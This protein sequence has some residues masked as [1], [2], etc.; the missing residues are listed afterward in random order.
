MLSLPFAISGPSSHPPFNISQLAC[1]LGTKNASIS[2]VTPR[3]LHFQH[4]FPIL[5]PELSYNSKFTC[6]T[7]LLAYQGSVVARE[8]LPPV[9]SY[10]QAHDD[11]VLGSISESNKASMSATSVLL[12][13]TPTILSG[14]GP[15]V[16]EVS[17]LSL[18]RPLLASLI[19]LG[20]PAIYP[21]RP[22]EYSDPFAV[23]QP[24]TGT[25][26]VPR[27]AQPYSSILC[28]IQYLLVAG[29][30]TNVLQVSYDIGI[31]S[32][33]D[34]WCDFSFAPLFWSLLTAGIHLTAA[35]ALRFFL[36]KPTG[37]SSG[38]TRTENKGINARMKQFIERESQLSANG[39]YDE[40]E[41]RTILPLGIGLNLLAGWLTLCHIA[42]GTAVFSRV[43]YVGVG[44][45]AKLILR[46]LAPGTICRLCLIF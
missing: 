2:S 13:L 37:Q 28:T 21:S 46:Y 3:P 43:L 23:F 6:E 25:I 19:S 24:A 16:A 35:L 42:F 18:R 39:D 12:G 29:A 11:C 5:E 44:D 22:M 32:V 7:T 26:V 45:A 30:A 8:E 27:I 4:W 40:I 41:N 9:W 36:T 31:R 1:Y 34:W 17:L 20:A 38:S 14:L 10:C 33:I 15:T